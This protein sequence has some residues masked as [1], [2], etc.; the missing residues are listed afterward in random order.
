VV[1][2]RGSQWTVKITREVMCMVGTKQSIATAYHGE[3]DSQTERIN[4]ILED[5]LHHYVAANERDW[6]EHLDASEF[7]VSNSWQ[8]RV[9]ETPF[10]L[11]SEHHPHTPMSVLVEHN[12]VVPAAKSLVLRLTE[13]MASAKKCMK[14]AQRR[15]KAFADKRPVD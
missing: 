6:D 9:E 8:A 14:A 12:S 15:Y 11:N 3:A 5:V 13:G 7:A 1:T 2:D 4:Q 10:V